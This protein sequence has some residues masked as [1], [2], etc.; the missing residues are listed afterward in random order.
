M[1][2]EI[3]VS[4]SLAVDDGIIDE[5]LA[6]S[7]LRF[8]WAG[9]KYT[10][11]VQSIGTS[12]EAIDLGEI[13]TLGWVLAIN[14]DNTNYVELRSATGA[15]NDIIKLPAKHGLALFHWGSDVSAP[16]AIANTSACRVAFLQLAGA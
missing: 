8:D 1:A 5:A 4:A 9:T 6:K 13:T 15:G 16:F 12:E 14:L 7:G 2:A 11:H 3:T 10:K